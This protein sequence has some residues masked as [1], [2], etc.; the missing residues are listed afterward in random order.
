MKL[1]FN[2]KFIGIV[3]FPFVCFVIVYAIIHK[4]DIDILNSHDFSILAFSDSLVHGTSECIVTKTEHSVHVQFQLKEGYQFPF[5]G[6]QIEKNNQQLFD[7]SHYTIHL[8]LLA[9]QDM[10]LS[11]RHN[12]FIPQYSDSVNTL[13]YALYLKTLTLEQGMNNFVIRAED[14]NE[15][16]EWWYTLNP[17]KTHDVLASSFEQTKYMWLYSESTI[18]LNTSMQ[19]EITELKL[20]YALQPLVHLFLYFAVCYYI[21]LIVVWKFKKNSIQKLFLPIEHIAIS[22]NQNTMFTEI[23]KILATEYR[24]PELK[25]SDVAKSAGI[26]D[27]QVSEILK[28][29]VDMNFKQYLNKIRIEESLHLLRNSSL[30]IS[31]IAFSVGYNSVQHFN[32]VFKECMNCSPG[33]YRESL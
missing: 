2:Y 1:V 23:V 15:I 28:Q 11:I 12:Q 30:Q 9:K 16:P 18:P 6:V 17:R 14:I 10:R 3:L 5:A 8:Q 31:E 29:H 21:I 13:S 20:V 22:Q 25:I 19:F 4:P 27:E 33:A 7:I 26:Y 24:N 32:R